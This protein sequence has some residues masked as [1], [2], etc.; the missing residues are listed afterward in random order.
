VDLLT[1]LG[2][3]TVATNT[4]YQPLIITRLDRDKWDDDGD[5]EEG[6]GLGMAAVGFT[7]DQFQSLPDNHP[8]VLAWERIT[9]EVI[10]EIGPQVGE[11]IYQA[12]E[13]RL[14]WTWQEEAQS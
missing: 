14:P 8:G 10:A 3:T 1:T 5:L 9:D 11:L 13:R 4:P 7:L 12:L 6:Q 2:G